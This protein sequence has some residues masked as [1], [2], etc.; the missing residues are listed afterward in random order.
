MINGINNKETLSDCN[1]DHNKIN[2]KEV[3]KLKIEIKV[4]NSKIDKLIKNLKISR[5]EC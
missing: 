4:K 5:N 1:Y 3:N 2:I